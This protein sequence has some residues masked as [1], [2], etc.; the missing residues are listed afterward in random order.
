MAKSIMSKDYDYIMV[1]RK[2]LGLFFFVTTIS[3]YDK[4]ALEFLHRTRDHY[5]DLWG[6]DNVKIVLKWNE[7]EHIF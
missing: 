1:Y 4:D 2:I 3:R 6:F 5:R 7:E